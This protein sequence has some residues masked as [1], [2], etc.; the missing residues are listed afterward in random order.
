VLNPENFIGYQ[1]K[2]SGRAFTNEVNSRVKELGLPI[3]IEQIGI[4]FRLFFNPGT[5][6]K[7]IAGFFCKDKTTI[8]RIVGTMERN[9][10]V[11]RVPSEIDK[12]INLLYLTNKGKELQSILIKVVLET[13]EKAAKGI[14]K[15]E[16]EITKKVLNQIKINL[17]DKGC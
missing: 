2:T 6:Q 15:E 5:T 1:L 3:T 9:D 12:R 16:L 4:I 13:S 17:D 7:D 11:V 14:S 10:L 8:A